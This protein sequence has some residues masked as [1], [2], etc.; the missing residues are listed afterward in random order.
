MD[1][2]VTAGGIPK[3][4]EPLYPYTQG[5]PKA[6]LD[7]CGKSMIQWVLDALSQAETIESVI[8]MGLTSD[9][10]VDCPKIKAF[11]PSQGGM[12]DN[13]RVGVQKVQ[14][15]NPAAHHAL[16]VSS[17]IPGI[18]PE[19]VDWVVR[20]AIETDEDIYYNVIS[21]QVMEARYPGSR[22]S[23]TRLKDVEVCGGDMNVIRTMTVTGNDELWER[24]IAARKNV[25][26]QA[27]LL[28]YDTLILLLFRLI[29]LEE[30]VKKVTRRVNLTGRA[31]LCPYAE[32]GMDVDK[33]H[34]LELMCADLA[35][36]SAALS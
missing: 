27:A 28:G 33:P 18:T 34:Q 22:R 26:K 9:S 17:D 23:Y 12:L 35:K 36:R 2:I 6:L 3:P 24:I 4:D 30:A 21:R 16:V 8:I 20:T 7:V 5:K 32:V 25:F 11:V 10:G 29:T 15:I 13:I 19:A 1:A 31:I 14:E